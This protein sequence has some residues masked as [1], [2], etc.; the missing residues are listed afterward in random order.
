MILLLP[1]LQIVSSVENLCTNVNAHKMNRDNRIG[2]ATVTFNSI[3]VPFKRMI[4]AWM[5]RRLTEAFLIVV[6]FQTT[7]QDSYWKT[8]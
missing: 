3:V 7:F 2:E 6:S 5:I 1:R 4:A 8:A